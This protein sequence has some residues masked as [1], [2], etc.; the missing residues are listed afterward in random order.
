[1]DPD[2]F[3]SLT[4]LYLILEKQGYNVAAVNDEYNPKDFRFLNVNHI[5]NPELNI[6]EFNPDLIISLD[7]ASL[8]QL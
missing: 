5:I 8:G 7:A 3:G 6:S 4:A 2:C 1:M